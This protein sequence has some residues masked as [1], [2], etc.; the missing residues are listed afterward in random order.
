[1]EKNDISDNEE[2]TSEIVETVPLPK[3]KRKITLSEE[4]RKRRG[5]NLRN[6]VA[7]KKAEN[8]KVN[9]VVKDEVIAVKKQSSKKIAKIK[10]QKALA[11][12]HPDS[13]SDESSDDE[14]FT[15]SKKRKN[16]NKNPTIIVKNYYTNPNKKEFDATE[17]VK[18]LQETFREPSPPPQPVRLG[19]FV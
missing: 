12:A 17:Q 10:M 9:A 3:Q 14:I 1:M 16:K 19:Y 6:I 8:D 2:V 5:D 11:L 4:E 18:T 7:K 15:S 13:D